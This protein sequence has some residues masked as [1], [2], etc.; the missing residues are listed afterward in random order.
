MLVKIHFGSDEVDLCLCA[1]GVCSLRQP[2][3]LFELGS[4]SWRCWTW[5]LWQ[6]N[7]T[8]IS[9]CVL[10]IWLFM[11]SSAYWICTA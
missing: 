8:M 10:S 5:L 1:T 3:V 6:V 4:T 9:F 7:W 11:N 2:L